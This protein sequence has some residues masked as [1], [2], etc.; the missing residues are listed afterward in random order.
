MYYIAHR[1]S[2]LDPLK[3]SGQFSPHY[4]SPVVFDI[5]TS[6]AICLFSIHQP[7]IEVY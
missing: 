2:L 5:N 4:A 7:S 6:M 3:D 1:Y